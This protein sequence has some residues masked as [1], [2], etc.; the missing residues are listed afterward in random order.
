[1]VQIIDNSPSAETLRM[2]ALSNPINQIAQGLSEFNEFNKQQAL[3][4]RQQAL[5]DQNTAL[6]FRR[7][8]YEVTP[9]MLQESRMPPVE[10][11]LI[12]RLLNEPPP[13]QKAPVDLFGK[14]TEE[15]IRKQQ[16]EE[17]K[18]NFDA[19][20][21][22]N[23]RRIKE[24]QI[25][26]QRQN[27]DRDY[28]LKLR[29]LGLKEKEIVDPS[30]KLR[31]E[32]TADQVKELSKKNANLYSVKTAMDKALGQLDDP[33]L[34]E[35]EKVKVGQGLLKLLNSAEGSDAVGAEEA[36]RIGDY[37]E[38]AYGNFT[39]VGPMRLGRDLGGFRDQV[40]NYRN[41]LGDRLTGNEKGIE[42]LYS[43]NKLSQ[44]DNSTGGNN[45][46]ANKQRASNVNASSN[47]TEVIKQIKNSGMSRAEKIKL[48]RGN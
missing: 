40:Q 24:N 34:N 14:R 41:L 36:K 45:P 17:K 2:R 23:E 8:G 3:T 46:M 21:A 18:Y 48:L 38:Y 12:S 15:F 1:M 47:P 37:L 39:G 9:E 27:S 7:A 20:E 13:E 30:A 4:K 32:A 10:Q 33:N 31:R 44:I 5:Q 28:Q 11:G 43:G 19:R 35:D 16:L 25:N 42:A 29:E 22:E 6:E 26:N